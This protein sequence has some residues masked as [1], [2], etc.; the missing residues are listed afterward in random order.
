MVIEK[1]I[2]LPTRRAIIEH[3]QYLIEIAPNEFVNLKDV[4]NENELLKNEIEKVLHEL[5][6]ETKILNKLKDHIILM[7]KCSSIQ[8][9]YI[10]E[11]IFDKLEELE[12]S[13]SND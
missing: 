4:I 7:R 3:N 6:K 13:D 12:E 10:F 8:E 11:S 2:I 1:E 9:D 5:E